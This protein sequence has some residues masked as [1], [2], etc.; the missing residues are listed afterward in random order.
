MINRKERIV[1]WLLAVVLS[2]IL[3]SLAYSLIP[4]TRSLIEHPLLEDFYIASDSFQQYESLI[5]NLNV[6]MKYAEQKKD[7]L[8][9]SD[10][11][12]KTLSDSI[13]IYD[14]QIFELID[15]QQ[16]LSKS[17]IAQ[18]NKLLY[19]YELK[20]FL[21][22]LAVILPLLLLTIFLFVRYRKY[23]YA[24]FLICFII[25]MTYLFVFELILYLPVYGEIWRYKLDMIVAYRGYSY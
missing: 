22:R 8:L 19:V 14:Q 11:Q 6:K 7:V 13:S 16:V 10:P 1:I 15:K 23:R 2:F 9:N 12:Q 5:Y 20:V 3:I 18:Y 24:P 17:I 25:L 21:L 4:K